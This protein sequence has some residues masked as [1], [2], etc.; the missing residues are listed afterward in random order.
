MDAIAQA[1]YTDYSY[2]GTWDLMT[3]MG[4]ALTAT[5]P[6]MAAVAS[7]TMAYASMSGHVLHVGKFLVPAGGTVL[8][9][10]AQTGSQRT[11]ELLR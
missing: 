8:G 3:T 9:H 5:I 1:A 10:S 2:N 11:L 4:R 7:P 6:T